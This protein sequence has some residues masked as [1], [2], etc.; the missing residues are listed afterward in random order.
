VN[1]SERDRGQAA[2]RNTNETV[3]TIETFVQERNGGENPGSV[4][5]SQEAAQDYKTRGDALQK[6]ASR[7]MKELKEQLAGLT[8]LVK[9]LKTRCLALPPNV[10]P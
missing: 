7:A 1:A 6:D 5:S 3:R 8:D 2:Y 10:N 9:G 4:E